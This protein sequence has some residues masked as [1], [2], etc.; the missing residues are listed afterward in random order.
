MKFIVQCILVLLSTGLFAQQIKWEGT[1]GGAGFEDAHVVHEIPGEGYIVMGTSASFGTGSNDC[2][3]LKLD[4]NGNE[5]WMKTYGGSGDEDAHYGVITSDGGFAMISYSNSFGGGDYDFYVIRT[6]ENGDTLWTRTYGDSLDQHGYCIQETPDGGFVLV[7]KSV[8][9]STGYTDVWVI[10]TDSAGNEEWGNYYGDSLDDYARFVELT[11]DGG[12]IIVGTTHNTD[13]GDAEMYLIKTD[14]VGNVGWEQQ[15]DENLHTFG[16]SVQQT[17]TGEYVASGYFSDSIGC[18][19]MADYNLIALKVDSVGN[20]LWRVTPFYNGSGFCKTYVAHS[21]REN[22]DGS[23]IISGASYVEYVCKT[24]QDPDSGLYISDLLML[25]LNPDGS[26][27]WSKEYGFGNGYNELGTF[28]VQTSDSGYIFCAY[29]GSDYETDGQVLVVKTDSLG[30]YINIGIDSQIGDHSSLEIFP[31]PCKETFT[32][33]TE[34]L[35]D[36]SYSVFEMGG[37]KTDVCG[38]LDGVY[39]QI[40]TTGLN[41]GFYNLVVQ[42]QEYR[43]V[44]KLIVTK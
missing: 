40:S 28:G 38:V 36:G 35:D 43:E 14:S 33:V 39:T 44:K 1:Y 11:D 9:D 42:W 30:Y 32:I 18:W 2:M 26:T 29:Q 12:Y 21:M 13:S 23:Y 6:D 37:R 16:Y 31:N 15:Y 41:P 25:K 3:M 5:L 27:D 8:R 20:Q 24:G 34:S 10:K 19:G 22:S 4:M 17:I 7:G